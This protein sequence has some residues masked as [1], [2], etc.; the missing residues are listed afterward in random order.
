[1]A[2]ERLVK[3]CRQRRAVARGQIPFDVARPAHAGNRRADVWIGEDEA[4]RQLGEIHAF[5][6]ERLETLDAGQSCRE[7]AGV[8]I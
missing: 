8:E 5:R 3:P 1:M 4:K 7:V 6:Q 2:A